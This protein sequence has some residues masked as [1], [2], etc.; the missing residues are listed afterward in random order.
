MLIAIKMKK[1]KKKTVVELGHNGSLKI[2][3]DP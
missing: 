1:K 3:V 2:C